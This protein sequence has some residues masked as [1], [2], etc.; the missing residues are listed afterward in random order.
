METKDCNGKVLQA[1]DTVQP[2]KDLPVKWSSLV[3]KKWEAIKKIQLTDD[4]EY[5]KIKGWI[6]LKTEFLK[7]RK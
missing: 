1:G 2:I 4:P 7:K 6:F 5:I 3:F